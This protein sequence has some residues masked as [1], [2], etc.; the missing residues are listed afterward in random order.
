MYKYNRLF[1]DI[2]TSILVVGVGP[3]TGVSTRAKAFR[4]LGIN[5][6][7]E[8]TAPTED[9]LIRSL[10][11]WLENNTVDKIYVMHSD[12]QSLSSLFSRINK[13]GS[14]N[15]EGADF[16]QHDVYTYEY[17]TFLQEVKDLVPEVI[18]NALPDSHPKKEKLLNAL[19]S[20][21]D[22]CPPLLSA[23]E[24]DALLDA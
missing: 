16:R 9:Q 7:Y 14:F 2:P 3:K 10:E 24:V 19:N 1:F 8:I 17:L 15:L 4:A 6:V 11:I 18:I 22:T 20:L 21:E 5:S 12:K 23:E 13:L